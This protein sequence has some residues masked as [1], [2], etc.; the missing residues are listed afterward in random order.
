MDDHPSE[1]KSP[2][3]H[4]IREI[5]EGQNAHEAFEAELEKAL[6]ARI[7]YII[8]EPARLGDETARWI[9]VGNC[10]HKTACF[11]GLAS[12]ASLSFWPDR[13]AISAA[14]LCAI[15]VFCTG[16]Y[17]ISWNYDPCCQYQ[18][19]RDTKKLSK[20]PN[21]NDFSS[22]VV[23]VFKSNNQTKY[24]HRSITLLSAAFCAWK[25]FEALK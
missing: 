18:V 6:V 9:T 22:P 20:V 5:Y 17:C 4:I 19:E 24:L 25:I 21:L 2:T 11:T 14:P 10:L 1:L 3:T 7:N 15:S 23:L 13:L 16:L 8:V 12:I